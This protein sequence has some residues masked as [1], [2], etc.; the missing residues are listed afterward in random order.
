MATDTDALAENTRAHQLLPRTYETNALGTLP[1]FSPHSQFSEATM[2]SRAC[3]HPLAAETQPPSLNNS[4]ELFGE[5][6]DDV[7]VVAD[8]TRAPFSGSGPRGGRLC[9]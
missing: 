2:G 8:D 4:D 9:V 3:Q 5:G 1:S 6:W 7:E